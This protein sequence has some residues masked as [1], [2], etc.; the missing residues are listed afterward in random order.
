MRRSIAGRV[1]EA[2]VTRSPPWE[3]RTSQAARHQRE[4]RARQHP[5]PAHLA[6][7]D[8]DGRHQVVHLET[9]NEVSMAGAGHQPGSWENWIENAFRR[10]QP[11]IRRTP[12]GDRISP[13]P[14]ASGRYGDAPARF[15]LGVPEAEVKEIVM[16]MDWEGPRWSCPQALFVLC[17]RVAH[18]LNRSSDHR[19]GGTVGCPHRKSRVLRSLLR[20]SSPPHPPG[21]RR[22]LHRVRPIAGNHHPHR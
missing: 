22:A 15:T 5:V 11:P 21:S 14:Q 16:K 10:I 1:A 13:T 18:R 12:L 9:A 17:A 20:H 3:R 7:L 2:S 19:V 4:R 6:A 8:L